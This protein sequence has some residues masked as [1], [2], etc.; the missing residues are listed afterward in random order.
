M[1]GLY[2]A[3]SEAFK[4]ASNSY[5]EFLGNNRIHS[6]YSPIYIATT[7]NVVETL[8]LYKNYERVLTVGGTGAHAYEALLNGAKEVDIF[9]IN[10]L[11]RLYFEYMKTAIIYLKYEDFIK[12]FTLKEQKTVFERRE[13]KDFLSNEL[14]YQLSFIVDEEIDIVFGPLYEFFDS[15][16]LLMSKLF[17]FEFPFTLEYLKKNASFYNEEQYYKLQKILRSDKHN[18]NYQTMSLV[19]V[20]KNYKNKYDL[21]L[22][23][24]ILQYYKHIPELETPYLVN[25]FIRKKLSE[26]LNDNGTIQVNCAYQLGTDAVKEKLG[27]ELPKELNLYEKLA[28]QQE[29]KEGINI[30]LIEKWDSYSYDFIPGVE[31]LDNGTQADNL[32]LSY[33]KSR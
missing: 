20:P 5:D 2:E 31:K 10:E 25:M 8:K 26:L 32:V 30:P 12:H 6:K 17:R 11:Q 22:L 13:I 21:I 28:L 27:L 15:T 29:I 7:S 23:D 9:D 18:I 33:K 24:N 16:D 3:R 19:D 14:Y 4:L 1:N